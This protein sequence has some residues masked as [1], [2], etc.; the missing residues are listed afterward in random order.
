[1]YTCRL[2]FITARK[3]QRGEPEAAGHTIH[4]TGNSHTQRSLK[5]L[6]TPSIAQGR[7]RERS[8]SQYPQRRPKRNEHI[9]NACLLS[10]IKFRIPKLGNDASHDGRS[11]HKSI[12]NQYGF[13][14]DMP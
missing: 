14:T 3:S 9:H 4:N 6:I 10:F 7:H 8:W 12:N 5:P 13:P 1:M 2:Q 11:L